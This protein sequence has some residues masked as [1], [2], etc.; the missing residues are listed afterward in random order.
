MEGEAGGHRVGQRRKYYSL[1]TG[2][3][4]W[5]EPPALQQV[6]RK[7]SDPGSQVQLS[8][9][10]KGGNRLEGSGRL[11]QGRKDPAVYCLQNIGENTVQE[12]HCPEHPP[13]RQAPAH[14]L[15]ANEVKAA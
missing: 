14:G 15:G 7:H 8:P 9:L 12:G 11:H 1:V 5:H 2:T 3:V 13:P 4:C 6:P 10:D